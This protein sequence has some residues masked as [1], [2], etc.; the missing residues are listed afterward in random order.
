MRAYRGVVKVMAP[1]VVLAMVGI[2]G[3]DVQFGVNGGLSWPF[4]EGADDF[5]VGFAVG[6]N[7]F[8]VATPNL[9]IGGR[10]AYNRWGIDE[11]EIG[12]QNPE[13]LFADVDGATHVIELIPSVRLRSNME[14]FLLNVF[15]QAG[16]G[17]YIRAAHASI[18]GFVDDTRVDRDVYD[19]TDGRL[20]LQAGGGISLGAAG[21]FGLELYPLYNLIFESD[22]ELSQYI[23]F[24][25]GVS[26]QLR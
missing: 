22:E 19:D 4:D 15:A 25:L 1:L 7:G 18:E 2:A 3:A 24:N 6:A 13:V 20:G 26:V 16:V 21:R 11:S 5:N 17:V 14:D 9:L 10:V 8:L 12:F 23:T